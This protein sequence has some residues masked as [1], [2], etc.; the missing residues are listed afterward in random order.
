MLPELEGLSH[1]VDEELL[2]ALCASVAESR[3]CEAWVAEH[4]TTYTTRD[5]K[6]QV[7]GTG[8]APKYR[9]LRALRADIVR[10]STALGL[11]P[12][13]RQQRAGLAP[14]A[15]AA[16]VEVTITALENGGRLTDED[17]ALV[18]MVRN[19]A[20][21]VDQAPGMAALWKEFRAAIA[22]LT[23]VGADDI[24]DDT[25]AFRV[26]IQ[27]PSRPSLGHPEDT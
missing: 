8:D 7:K 12:A 25:L 19:L 22:T 11:T 15:N 6:G 20:T 27:T 2:R 26:S 9:Q 21:A 10:L 16:A 23:E 5:D 13:S 3:T 17:A 18:A 14:G 24:D 1:S 4:G